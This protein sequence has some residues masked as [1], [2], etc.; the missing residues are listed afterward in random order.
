MTMHQD[1]VLVAVVVK[2][3]QQELRNEATQW[4]AAN[5]AESANMARKG[6]P[7]TQLKAMA[8]SMHAISAHRLAVAARQVEI[9]FPARRETPSGA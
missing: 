9:R 1:P 4:H 3:R 5:V 6:W 8:A 7:W 2:Q